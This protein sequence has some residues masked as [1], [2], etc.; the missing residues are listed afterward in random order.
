MTPQEKQTE[1]MRRVQLAI[2][3]MVIG[4]IAS[5]VEIADLNATIEAIKSKSE[6]DVPDA[7]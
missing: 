7:S 6:A 1:T 2:G 3:E 5:Q 4:S